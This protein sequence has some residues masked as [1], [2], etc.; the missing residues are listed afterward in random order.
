MAREAPSR[1]ENGINLTFS[2]P[3]RKVYD[4]GK[5]GMAWNFVLLS[6]HP[7]CVNL[8]LEFFSFNS[9]EDWN[10]VFER[11]TFCVWFSGVLEGSI[12]S[13]LGCRCSQRN[14]AGKTL[15]LG[16]MVNIP[17]LDLGVELRQVDVPA[18]K[19]LLT[20]I[21]AVMPMGQVFPCTHPN[22]QSQLICA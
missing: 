5:E 17:Y 3:E 13:L 20:C 15:R 9:Q 14:Q 4:R 10:H 12:G 16:Q 7:R 21:L 2:I 8:L 18:G 11:R 19:L 22:L 1:V 6:T